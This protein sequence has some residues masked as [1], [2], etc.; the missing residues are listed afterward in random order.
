MKLT[1]KN[2]QNHL[3]LHPFDADNKKQKA[4]ALGASIICGIF[5]LGICHAVCGIHHRK[6]KHLKAKTNAHTQKQL[7]KSVE[8]VMHEDF[9]NDPNME[10]MHFDFQKRASDL[11]KKYPQLGQDQLVTLLPHDV[12]SNC[13]LNERQLK[14]VCV[15]LVLTD[16]VN[17]MG[18]A[19]GHVILGP[20]HLVEKGSALF[21][22]YTKV[23]GILKNTKR[24]D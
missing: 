11:L 6:V 3:I 10:F 4:A 17:C 12:N 2:F 8:T 5:S 22:C 13:Y 1:F 14:A 18:E 24:T 20:K 23:D 16:Q 9:T 21:S 7:I 19:R 15:Y